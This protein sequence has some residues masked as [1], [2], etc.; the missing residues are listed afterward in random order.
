M[1]TKISKF[2]SEVSDEEIFY[3]AILCAQRLLTGK[4]FIV[5]VSSSVRWTAA[6]WNVA[7]GLA[8]GVSA[9]GLRVAGVETLV[10]DTGVIVRTLIVI[11]TFANFN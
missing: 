9:A 3:N 5:W 7:L 1:I 8:N 10:L 4:A 11:L 2:L 6:D